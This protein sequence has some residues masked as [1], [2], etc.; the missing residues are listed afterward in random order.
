MYDI[1]NKGYA[2][3]YIHDRYGAPNSS[4]AHKARVMSAYCT[5]SDTTIYMHCSENNLRRLSRAYSNSQTKNS[6]VAT[7]TSEISSQLCA[8]EINIADI[9]GR[10]KR[11]ARV[12]ER[13]SEFKI[14]R[15][16]SSELKAQTCPFAIGDNSSHH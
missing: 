11:E 1:R 15:A 6:R 13:F 12:M 14:E 16:R 10:L 9:T 7:A 3:L 2:C 8:R 4:F 5:A